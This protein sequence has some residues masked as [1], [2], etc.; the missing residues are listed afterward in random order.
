[1]SAAR[2]PDAAAPPAPDG[3]GGAAANDGGAEPEV[4]EAGECWW[5]VERPDSCRSAGLPQPADRPAEGPGDDATIDDIYLGLARVRLGTNDVVGQLS[6]DV[7]QTIGFDLDGRCTNSA[8]CGMAGD[9]SCRSRSPSLPFDGRFCR[10]NTFAR[11]Q[12]LI[13]LGPEVSQRFGL[14]EAMLN[15]Q[16]ARGTFNMVVRVRGY[17]GLADDAH[18]RVD[19]YLSQGLEDKASWTC[20][21][22]EFAE[23][24]RWG[25][26]RTWLVD[27][28]LLAQQPTAAGTWPD[29]KFADDDAYVKQGYLVARVPD[30]TEQGFMG[31]GEQYRGFLFRAV[32]AVFVGRLRHAQDDTWLVE[33]GMLAGR[34]PQQ[35]LIRSFRES[36]LCETPGSQTFYQNMRYFVEDMADLLA[37][38]ED[39]SE[40]RCDAMSYAIGFTAAQ[41][42]PGA[43]RPA[44]PRVECCVPGRRLDECVSQCG[45]GIVQ[46]DEACD[47][48]IEAG[49][50][51]ACPTACGVTEACVPE[52]LRGSGCL[53]LCAPMPISAAG[54][55]DGCC[56]RGGDF[57]TDVDCQ[58]E[59]NNGVVE[60]GETCDPPG[61]C[62]EC[63]AAPRC[64]NPRR[65]GSAERCNLRCEIVPVTACTAGDGCCPA[66]CSRERD[67]D[68]SPSCGN[69]E[70]EAGEL[71]ERGG[72][73]PCSE[74]CDDGDDCTR[75]VT[76][77]SAENCSLVCGHM[78]ITEARSGDGC[79][80]DGISASL[81]SDCVAECGNKV[82]EDQEQCDDGNKSA[83]D[84]CFEC[85]TENLQQICLAN[86]GSDDAC[87][88]CRCANCATQTIGCYMDDVPD[89]ARRC[90]ELVE[91]A[92]REA[93]ANPDCFCGSAPF[94]SCLAGEGDG[95][96][97]MAITEAA[98]STSLIDIDLR[99]TD[100]TWPLGRGNQLF[101]CTERSCTAE[102]NVPLPQN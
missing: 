91:C 1:M 50:P 83:G 41:V 65:S 7:W 85:K 80:P 89:E 61:S 95:P 26:G 10:D 8:T 57:M 42:T 47:V 24:P 88:R 52:V 76:S 69:G 96:C 84:G 37:S 3:N 59:C 44:P 39:D 38:G 62:G 78:P 64:F 68:C 25:S 12:S 19:Y 33:D 28:G 40:A 27:E 75:D 49:A 66:G 97:R 15:C 2:A 102:C 79:C 21:D 93:C 55:K 81:D 46:G 58:S 67:A 31:D 22:P 9:V 43:A 98:H 63:S 13:A 70:L 6:E 92:R 34:L 51:G 53:A 20:P 18:V 45:D 11:L 71:C 60:P 30:G 99:G 29:S 77:G 87:A 48:A 73:Q 35:E 54:A 23:Y 101:T 72:E 5:S 32:G 36:G 17:G 4:C 90:R 94:F 74:S 16:L 56:P 14:T 100:I 82:V 86:V